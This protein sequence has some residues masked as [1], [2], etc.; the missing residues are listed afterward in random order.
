MGSRE[1]KTQ[2]FGELARLGKALASP[3]RLELLE[4]LTQAPHTVEGLALLT[5]QSVANTSHHLKVLR[6]AQLVTGTKRGNELWCKVAGPDVEQ[7]FCGLRGVGLQHLAELDR[8][9][10]DGEAVDI[11][12][13]RRRLDAGEAV[14][15]DVR[16]DDEFAAGHLPGALSIPVD[17]LAERLDELPAGLQA[18]AYCRGPLCTFASEAVKLL[19]S[20]GM[21]AARLD[22]G[23][24]DWRGRGL[25][26][27]VS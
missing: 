26:I 19:Q 20:A 18:V 11:E 22:A 8:L 17:E 13:L 23:V 2:V 12:E 5:E 7:L 21:D 1:R 9:R 10:H 25:A 4:L 16:P 24:S 6:A 27:E 3:V 14:L 15:I